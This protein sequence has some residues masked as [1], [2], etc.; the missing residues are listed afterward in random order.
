MSKV[1][2]KATAHFRNQISGEMAKV[3]VPEWDADIYYKAINTLREESKVIE[4][5]QQGK[6]VEALVETLIMKARNQDGTKMFGLA[7]KMILMNEVDP[8]VIIRVV[9]E[10]NMTNAEVPSVEDAQKN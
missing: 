4:L 5:A 1:L 6:T 10:L 3:H 8:Q 7:D 2:D 9:G